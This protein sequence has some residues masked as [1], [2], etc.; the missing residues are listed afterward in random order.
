MAHASVFEMLNRQTQRAEPNPMDK[1]TVVSIFPKIV[2]E[3]KHT[4]QPGEFL[5]PPGTYEK[6]TILTV[7]SSSWWRDLGPDEPLLEIPVSS[8]LIAD[9]VVRD[10]CNGLIECDMATKMP[11]L[12]YVPGAVSV[13][14]IQKEFK[15]QLDAARIKQNAWF[16][17][18]IELADSLWARTNGNPNSV[19]GDARLAAKELGLEKDWMKNY[20]AAGFVKCFACGNMRNP[21]YPICPTCKVIDPNHP[22][23]GKIRIAS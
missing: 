16:T 4:I 18:L 13:S 6:P 14:H 22:D 8:I 9:S 5:L 21:L 7:G 17:R 20:Q 1:A 23:A 3:I 12:F 2:H 15:A 19:P 10:Y 11:G